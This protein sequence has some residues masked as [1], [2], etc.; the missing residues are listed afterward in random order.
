MNKTI[1]EIT[2]NFGVQAF[3]EGFYS[4]SGRSV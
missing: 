4:N 2:Y 3:K 1:E